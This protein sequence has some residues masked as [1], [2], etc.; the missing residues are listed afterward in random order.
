MLYAARMRAPAIAALFIALI[1]QA[2]PLSDEMIRRIA[3]GYL[4]GT[5]L[6]PLDPEVSMPEALR[7]QAKLVDLLKSRLGPVAGYKIGLITQE[8]Q[9]RNNTDAPVRGVLLQAMLFSDNAELAASSGAQLTLEVDMGVFV[10]DEG[11]NDATTLAEVVT[12]LSDLVCFIE[13]TD[14]FAAPRQPMNAALLTALNV[15]A[16]A[17]II[18]QRRPLTPALVDAIP[19]MRMVLLDDAGTVIFDVPSLNVQPLAN[20]AWLVAELKKA[21][22]PLK[23]GDFI[24]LGSPAPMQPVVAG[25]RVT[26]RYEGL[27]GGP[28]TSTV[29]I[30]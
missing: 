14:S 7:V 6:P 15:Y 4:A 30:R 11:V 18:G 10:K 27:P 21:G 29:K 3:D 12:H 28:M 9:A 17:G 24:S 25:R 2:G 8:A 23:E 5:R 20:I 22:T 1:S 19:R 13:L 26:L 16:R